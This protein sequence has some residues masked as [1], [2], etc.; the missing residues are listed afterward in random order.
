MA[1]HYT[2]RRQAVLVLGM[3]RSGTSALSGTLARLGVQAPKTLMVPARDNPRG[4]WESTALMG[5]HD[6]VLASA[7]TA[8]S[9][10]DRFNPEWMKSAVAEDFIARLPGILE[11]EYGDARLLL[12]KDPRICRLL[13]LW[14]RVLSD[15]DITPKVVL[16]VRHPLEVARSLEIRNEFGRQRSYLTWLRHML[17]AEYHSRGSKRVVI[18]YADMLV[19]WR[20]QVERMSAELGIKWPKWSSSVEADIDGFLTTELRHHVAGDEI[21]ADS[22]GIAGWVAQ[23]R[24]AFLQLETPGPASDVA[25]RAL[26][27]LRREFDQ[28]SAVYAAV[29]RECEIKAQAK[30]RELSGRMAETDEQYAGLVKGLGELAEAIE[31]G[32]MDSVRKPSTITGDLAIMAEQLHAAQAQR[33]QL[34]AVDTEQIA[35]LSSQ[36]AASQASLSQAAHLLQATAAREVKLTDLQGQLDALHAQLA[37]SVA[38]HESQV[39]EIAKLT[40]MVFDLEREIAKERELRARDKLDGDSRLGGLERELELHRRLAADRL[41]QVK[42]VQEG[43]L[44]K[45]VTLL[46]RLAM[47]GQSTPLLDMP[48]VSDVETIQQ[49]ELFDHAWYLRRYPDVC[50]KGM[51]PLKHYLRYGATEGRD[52][53]P[54]F[55]TR[56]YL[57]RYPDVATSGINPLLHYVRYGIGEGRLA[58]DRGQGKAS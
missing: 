51:D 11:Q 27:Q 18:G 7:G 37:Q 12:V 24:Q 2:S 34:A 3:H 19:D 47:P 40:T 25:L 41:D 10:W 1:K 46:R 22:S 14:L 44:W 35:D 55:S 49:S 53:G 38:K 57:R 54:G 58:R 4:Y 52:P 26:D 29:V 9:D 16:P 20:R 42:H 8:W 13:P 33:T 56:D 21:T 36:L 30:V 50:K 31:A 28:S 23:A 5:F 43:R 15:L 48:V 17:D 45:A 39:A 32:E 6:E